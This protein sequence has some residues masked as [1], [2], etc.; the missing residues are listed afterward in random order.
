MNGRCE[1]PVGVFD[2]GCGGISVLIR[3][4]ALLPHEDFLYYG[5]NAYAPYGG[6][7]RE[8]VTARANAIADHLLARGAKALVI[9]CNTATAAA[10]ETLR[11]RFPDVPV[12]GMEP[13]IKPA[14]L[15]APRPHVLIMATEMTLHLEKF[16][17]LM[18]S[19]S[20]EADFDLLPCPDLVRLVEEGLPEE[21][22]ERRL[23]EILAPWLVAP[24]A[25]PDC[26]VLGCTHFPFAR[27][28]ISRIFGGTVDF[29]D[30][31]EGTARQLKHRLEE[32]SLISP[33]KEKRGRTVLE[34]S[35]TDPDVMLRMERF[36]ETPL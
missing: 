33:D 7:T 15:S 11:A 20:D 18:Q 21:K 26:I 29:Y 9:A 27:P 19:L 22:T 12:I 24:S 13:A 25:A 16:R 5:D 28:V 17:A 3:L 36:L 4:R 2:S 1:N 32:C 34:S 8:E 10:A 23:R 14:A 6:K 31:A 30:G 35:S